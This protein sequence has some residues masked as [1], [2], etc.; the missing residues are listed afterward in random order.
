MDKGTHA[1]VG[2]EDF[3]I[4]RQELQRLR[5]RGDGDQASAT[6]A[7]RD[8]WQERMPA[9]IPANVHVRILQDTETGQAIVRCS[10]TM[11]PMCVDMTMSISSHA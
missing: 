3:E 4:L 6:H 11:T 2:P 10:L 9:G 8:W 5:D 7:V 1:S